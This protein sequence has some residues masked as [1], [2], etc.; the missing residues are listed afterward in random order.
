MSSIPDRPALIRSLQRYPSKDTLSIRTA[1]EANAVKGAAG[2]AGD[3]AQRGRVGNVLAQ[4]GRRLGAEQGEQVGAEAGDVRGGHGSA[5]DG[6]LSCHG[7][8]LSK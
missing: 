7:Q 2:D 3:G 1:V 4:L 8:P 5:R 6:V